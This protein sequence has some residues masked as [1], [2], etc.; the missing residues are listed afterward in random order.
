MEYL[1]IILNKH[2]E[3]DS[4]LYPTISKDDYISKIRKHNSIVE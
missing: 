3:L 1:I 2:D 4:N